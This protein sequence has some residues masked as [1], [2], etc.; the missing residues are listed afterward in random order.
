MKR[1]TI[2]ALI[3]CFI[4][5]ALFF[6]GKK[7]C[8]ET[9]SAVHDS[10]YS[11]NEQERAE[12][13]ETDSYSSNAIVA[14][15][16]LAI[17][18]GIDKYVDEKLPDLHYCGNDMKETRNIL[19]KIGFR[20]DDIVMMTSDSPMKNEPLKKNIEKKFGEV[21]K[22]AEKGDMI[23]VAFSGH[24]FELNSNH[25]FCP[26]DFD[27]SDV[28]ESAVSL[29]SMMKQL[30]ESQ[31]SFRW[32][33]IDACRDFQSSTRSSDDLI[34][35]TKSIG[36]E[37]CSESVGFVMLQSCSTGEKSNEDEEFKLGL[38]TRVL[39]DAMRGK[40][41]TDGNGTVTV[42][43]LCKYVVEETVTL[44]KNFP[45]HQHPSYHGNVA[46]F[47]VV[48]D[49]A[50][51]KAE[52][53][54]SEYEM[55]KRAGDLENALEKIEEAKQI[56]SGTAKYES[57]SGET[58][59]AILAL[60]AELFADKKFPEVISKA[61]VILKYDLDN[62]RAQK[63]LA[64]AEKAAGIVN[65]DVVLPPG[66]FGVGKKAGERR[67]A[68]IDEV[69]YVFRWCPPGDFVMGSPETEEG[70]FDENEYIYEPLKGF[71]E[72]GE[73][74]TDENQHKVILTS[75]FWLLETPVTVGMWRSFVRATGYQSR[76]DG[77]VA[78]CAENRGC[79]GSISSPYA[80]W[81]NPGFFQGEDHPV[82]EVSW[83]DAVV[84]CRWLTR[85][86]N[87]GGRVSLP[88]ESEWEY[89]CR[90]GTT[91]AYGGTGKAEEM[92]WGRSGDES[93]IGEV[94][95]LTLTHPV[96]QKY[97]NDWGLYDMNGNVH[98]WCS[99][100]YGDYPR[101][102]VTDPKGPGTG[103]H[104]VR[105]GA[106]WWKGALACRSAH[107]SC[108]WN[109][110][111]RNYSTGFRCLFKEYSQNEPLDETA[112]ASSVVPDEEDHFD[113][114]LKGTDAEHIDDVVDDDPLESFSVLMPFPPGSFADGSIAG[115]RKTVRVNGVEYA[116][117]W[118]PPGTFTMGSPETEKGR[119]DDETEHEV[120]L[121]RGFWLLETPVTLEMWEN[122][123]GDKGHAYY[124]TDAVGD[125]RPVTNVNWNLCHEFC[126]KLSGIIGNATLTLPTEAE[127]EYAC[128]AG[129]TGAF[130][131]TGNIDDMGWC[132]DNNDNKSHTVGEK[133]P[134]DWGLFDMNGLV[135]EWCEDWYDSYPKDAVT[136][137]A[138]PRSGEERVCRGGFM[139]N[140]PRDCRSAVRNKVV[141]WYSSDIGFRFLVRESQP[142]E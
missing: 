11:E 62:E 112:E 131:G 130:G 4:S 72:D 16:R 100:W 89:A 104:R 34:P 97:P 25:Y 23:F 81:Q 109:Q 141:P 91:G 68:Q 124:P 120:T 35:G 142:A 82:L 119:N 38:F 128:R 3:L 48:E 71:R 12:E 110:V 113:A 114:D 31:A 43:E 77:V 136:D 37:K 106:P 74:Q 103:S 122:V 66:G 137:P 47:T 6:I 92:G 41:D 69:E 75:G 13:S 111:D 99:D 5:L 123:M 79:Y 115:E 60:C 96:R 49:L 32:V 45:Y 138:G 93:I 1:L 36:L 9:D 64:E 26:Q 118:C 2:L 27:V 56:K 61:K 95:A 46:D 127:W 133:V 78:L 84:F 54:Y 59:T 33:A 102:T 17:L 14:K 63:L 107:R 139:K 30:E 22:K 51:K 121:T 85:C 73:N 87:C 21:L 132:S 18:I 57:A 90:A 44:S 20:D 67:I 50:T 117:R 88:T 8:A 125:L 116:F 70:H 42:N 55:Y 108:G 24:G 94:V 58:V 7:L 10:P 40:A 15:R 105:R 140:N 29:T 80:T 135:W 76:G 39:L 98:E 52:K 28:A 53:L 83:D 86:L 19:L 126:E 129:T 65:F 101:G 134:N